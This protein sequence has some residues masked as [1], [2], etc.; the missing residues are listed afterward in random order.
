MRFGECDDSQRR[1]PPE[2]LTH[3]LAVHR[4]G[5]PIQEGISP[6]AVPRL[7]LIKM[8]LKPDKGVANLRHAAKLSRREYRRRDADPLRR[9]SERIGSTIAAAIGDGTVPGNTK[10]LN[11]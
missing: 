11:A 4:P 9:A 2:S 1:N 5:N 6:G 7:T 3:G 10:S 8:P